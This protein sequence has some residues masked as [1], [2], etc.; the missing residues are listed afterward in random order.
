MHFSR[1]LL[2]DFVWWMKNMA[3]LLSGRFCTAHS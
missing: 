1:G 2:F 3:T